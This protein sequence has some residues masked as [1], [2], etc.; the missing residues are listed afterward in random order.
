M[1]P[2]HS[3]R[4]SPFVVNMKILLMLQQHMAGPMPVPFTRWPPE[5]WQWWRSKLPGFQGLNYWT[6]TGCA[7]TLMLLGE[8]LQCIKQ[9]VFP[10]F[11]GYW[12]RVCFK[13]FR[14]TWFF[15]LFIH[16]HTL[17]ESPAAQK[18]CINAIALYWPQDG[19]LYIPG[20][21]QFLQKL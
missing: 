1:G 8:W 11:S 18:D 4:G 17:I 5:P 3:G 16:I 9:N 10:P 7:V 13:A 15:V 14:L 20:F 2:F 19:E 12:F 6:V 21:A